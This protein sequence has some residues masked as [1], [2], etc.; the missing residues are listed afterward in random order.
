MVRNEISRT[1]TQRRRRRRIRRR[2]RRRILI[3]AFA[4]GAPGT[5][6]T[7]G[8][9]TD[10]GDCIRQATVLNDITAYIQRASRAEWIVASL[11]YTPGLL[12]HVV[13]AESEHLSIL[14]TRTFRTS[15]LL[16]KQEKSQCHCP[17]RPLPHSQMKPPPA[18]RP[19]HQHLS[20]PQSCISTSVSP[21]SIVK[22]T[23]TQSRTPCSRCCYISLFPVSET[24]GLHGSE[25]APFSLLWRSEQI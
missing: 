17:V 25:S 20:Q 19:Q 10:G 14:R 15:N 3:A 2:R 21:H 9:H 23:F 24:P 18:L 12:L 6:G 4:C 13:L 1:R 22:F 8:L 11:H 16:T 5:Y 7:M